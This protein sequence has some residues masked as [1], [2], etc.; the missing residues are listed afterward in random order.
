MKK[1]L[2]GLTCVFALSMVGCSDTETTTTTETTTEASGSATAEATNKP[3]AFDMD[4]KNNSLAVSPDESIAIVC[5]S[6]K[7]E[8]KVY[9]LKNKKLLNTLTDFVTPRNIAFSKDGK[10]FYVSDSSYGN[11]REYDAQS[12]ELKRTFPLE[13]G[14]FGFRINNAGDKL[15]ANN[16]A[17]STVTV[18]DLNKGE[19]IKVIEGFS[20]PRQGIVISSDDKYAYVTNF[21]G[22]DVRVVNTETYEIEK[23]LTGIP[24]VRAI[25]I[26]KDNKYLYGASSS[27]NS[28]NVVDIGE[29]KVVKTIPVGEEPYGAA[30]SPDGKT[31]LTGEKGSNQVSVIDVDSLEVKSTITGLDAPRQAISYSKANEGKAYVLNGDL[32]IAVVDYVNNKIDEVIK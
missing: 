7:P 2:L 4:I 3:E 12:L 27:E 6:V 32:S 21:E 23:T 22:N 18:I 28:I 19:T 29:N 13:Q 31:I 1:Y 11:I 10:F 25:S 5:N 30:L 24:S 26:D 16:Q 9:D 8:L 17:K 14:V 15:F 20:Q